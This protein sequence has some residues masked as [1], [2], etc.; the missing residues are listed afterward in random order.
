[1]PDGWSPTTRTLDGD[2]KLKFS[3]DFDKVSKSSLV[4]TL[5]LITPVHSSQSRY[6]LIMLDM[7]ANHVT[8]REQISIDG[9]KLRH[10]PFRATHACPND[11][12]NH[13]IGVQCDYI[14]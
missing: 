12:T 11:W 13:M 8:S 10:S 2:V 6:S 7:P 4:M 3:Y 9:Q 5:S 1:V 14:P